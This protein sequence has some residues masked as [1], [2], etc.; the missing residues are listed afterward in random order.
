MQCSLLLLCIH[1]H[2]PPSLVPT[3]FVLPSKPSQNKATH[4]STETPFSCTTW[5]WVL[6]GH[7]LQF[8]SPTLETRH[9]VFSPL[10]IIFLLFFVC[11]YFPG[12]SVY[13]LSWELLFDAVWFPCLMIKKCLTFLCYLWKAKK[14]KEKKHIFLMRVSG[15]GFSVYSIPNL[16]LL[17]WYY[18]LCMS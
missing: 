14:I 10:F 8:A 16:N 1:H 4:F 6:K 2:L 12:I 9:S 18:S 11:N 15:V 17:W 5:I 7:C 3:R 13:K